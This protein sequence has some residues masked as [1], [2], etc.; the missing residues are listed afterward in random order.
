VRSEIRYVAPGLERMLKRRGKGDR[1]D[2]RRRIVAERILTR[3]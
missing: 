2:V 1:Y 3:A